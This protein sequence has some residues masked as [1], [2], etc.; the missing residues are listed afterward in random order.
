MKLLDVVVVFVLLLNITL[1]AAPTTL[2]AVVDVVA[3]PLNA[4]EN[5]VQ[6]SVLVDD[7]NVKSLSVV[8]A[9]IVP[10]VK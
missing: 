3:F 2:V 10:D 4:P 7:V 1:F 9:V 8:A 6:A 5:V